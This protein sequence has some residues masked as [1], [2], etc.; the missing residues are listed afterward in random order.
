[1]PA[2][3]PGMNPY[4]EHPD[5]WPQVHAQLIGTLA[6]QI[7]HCLPQRYEVAVRKRIYRVSGE[8]ALVVGQLES[9]PAAN[10]V[11]AAYPIHQSQL[12]GATALSTQITAADAPTPVY[13]P[14]PQEVREDYIEVIET[15]TSTA[16]TTLEILTPQRKRFGRGRERY[17][18]HRES[19]LGSAMHFIEIDLLRGWEPLT[20]YGP[21]AEGD[22]RILVSRSQD[23]PQAA[24]YTWHVEQRIPLFPLPLQQAAPLLNLKQALET[25]P[26]DWP[27]DYSLDPLPPLQ[28]DQADWLTRLLEEQALR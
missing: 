25:L 13:V 10:E 21:E 20:V 22:Y 7:E 23:R 15:E 19:I 24:L 8:D 28:G 2:Q 17:E 9:E 12:N 26:G 6:R 16:I 27:I 14:V 4:L 18:Q 5:L 11:A 1:M 3:F